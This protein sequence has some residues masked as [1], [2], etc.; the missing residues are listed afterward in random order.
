MN[1]I[2]NK[3]IRSLK[4]TSFHTIFF[5]GVPV[6]AIFFKGSATVPLIRL[7]SGDVVFVFRYI[8]ENIELLIKFFL[9]LYGFSSMLAF[10]WLIG[11]DEDI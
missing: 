7:F 4:W 3:I 6:V 10:L 11:G 1:F 8:L 2:L 5:V 9:A